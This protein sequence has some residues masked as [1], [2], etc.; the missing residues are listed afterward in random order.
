MNED[1]PSDINQTAKF[2]FSILFAIFFLYLLQLSPLVHDLYNIAY[3]PF[4][5][6]HEIGHLLASLIILPTV[7][8]QF[9]ISHLYEGGCSNTITIEELPVCWE[10]IIMKL[11]GSLMV[12]AI[13]I[14]GMI[15]LRN[16]KSPTSVSGGKFLIF[17]LLNNLINLFPILPAISGSVNDGYGICIVLLRMGHSTYPSAE[18]SFLFLYIASLVTL[19]SFYYLGSCLYHLLSIP[20]FKIQK[21]FENPTEYILSL[22]L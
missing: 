9:K 12:L 18:F 6:L 4:N 13:T 10:S 17:G 3:L 14:V 5:C 16:R 20:G 21:Q 1:T 15:A 2:Y 8:S 19:V 11:S 7:D 22:K